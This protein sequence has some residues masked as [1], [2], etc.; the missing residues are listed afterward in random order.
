MA[1]IANKFICSN[2]STLPYT[3]Y[4]SNT[5]LNGLS[6]PAREIVINLS[7]NILYY[8]EQGSLLRSWNVGSARAGKSTPTGEFKIWNKDICPPYYGSKGD[9]NVPG[10]TAQNPF[11]PKALWFKGFMYGI[12]GTN[13]TAL[14]SE[15]STAESRRVSSG[16]VR[17][18][19]SN[20]NWL[21][22][23]VQVDDPVTITW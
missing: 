20:I 23:K 9:K 12:H 5:K 21:F 7:D 3:E 19:N 2:K 8:Y 17:N 15:K 1:F 13:E 18:E 16:C 11:G 4:K 10:C 14:L 6:G 22:N